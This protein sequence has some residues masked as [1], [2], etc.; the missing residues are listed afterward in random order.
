[1]VKL[2]QQKMKKFDY[3]FTYFDTIYERD[4]QTNGHRAARQHRPRYAQRRTAKIYTNRKP[5]C[6]FLLVFHCNYMPVFY[7]FRDVTIYWSKR[8]FFAVL[9]TP[10]SS[11]ANKLM[12][13]N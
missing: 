8:C 7:R 2:Y 9:L 10:V 6:D 12:M 11:E 4:G 5:I 3:M 13:K 1:M